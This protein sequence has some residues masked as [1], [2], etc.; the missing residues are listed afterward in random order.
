MIG[1]RHLAKRF[2]RAAAKQAEVEFAAGLAEEFSFGFATAAYRAA[3]SGDGS[4]MGLFA[5]PSLILALAGLCLL[6]GL[7][8]YLE[9]GE[10][11]SVTAPAASSARGHD[12]GRGNLVAVQP[13]LVPQDYASAGRLEAKLAGYLGQAA[14][15]GWLGPKTI[16]VFPE[17]AGTWLAVAGEAPRIRAEPS[18]DIAMAGL[19]LSH[20]IDFVRWYAAAPKGVDRAEWALFTA[21]APAMAR[22]YQAVFGRLAARFK[23]TIV[24]GSIILPAPAVVDGRLVPHPGGALYN[25]AAVFDPNGRLAPS[26]TVKAYPIAEELAFVARGRAGDIP[27][28]RTP[29]G[30][31]AVVVCADSWYP[32]VYRRLAQT[33][34]ELLAVP[35]F[36]LEDGSWRAPWSGYSGAPNPAD[37]DRRDLGRLREDA[38][39]TKYSLGRAAAGLKAGVIVSLRG[40]LWDLGS[41]G[42]TLW[43]AGAARGQ[44]P[45]RPGASLFSLWL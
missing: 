7:S 18:L 22:D 24:A 4:A 14:A 10:T 29:A 41:D 1:Y 15:R 37:I 33:H 44:L 20:P 5:R 40:K 35:S 17:Y 32:D 3:S 25:V 42:E 19:A 26:L 28:Y 23:V 2:G 27:V 13:Y 45:E 8:I 36:S 6:A 43:F 12:G 16:V 21:K 30:R 31:L 9:G 38:A 34:A 11:P 39:W